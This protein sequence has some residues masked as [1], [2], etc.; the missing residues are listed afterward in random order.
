MAGA[1]TIKPENVVRLDAVTLAVLAEITVAPHDGFWV[2]IALRRIHGAR[3][4]AG[5]L[6][7]L[8]ASNVTGFG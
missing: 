5:R 1:A 7:N 6:P 3:F 2:V 8:G 4:A